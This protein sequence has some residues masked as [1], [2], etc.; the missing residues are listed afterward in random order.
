MKILIASSIDPDAIKHLE[1]K[2]DVICAF[3]AAEDVLIDKIQD[4][5]VLVFRSGVEITAKVMA[6]A[7]NL[8]LILRGGSGADNI[9][10]DYVAQ[11]DFEFIRIPGPG[12]RAVA[13][14]ALGFMFILARKVFLADKMTRQGRWM[15]NQMTGYLLKGKTLGIVGA[16]NIGTQTGDLGI[17]LGMNAI[18]CVHFP[19]EEKERE[20]KEHGIC[21][22]SFEEVISKSDFICLHV[23]LED[24]TRH[25]IN[26]QTL[27]M[28]KPGAYLI[29]LARGGV[30]DEAALYDALTNQRLAGAALDV[31]EREG[32]GKI[33]PLAELDNVVLTPHIG[34]SAFDSQREIGLIII[35]AVEQ[36]AMRGPNHSL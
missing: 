16:G 19:S 27:A 26:A 36:M 13:E 6:A 22:T 7:P 12:A 29:N 2:H 1:Q 11:R 18:G 10:L 4:R 17:A 9:D 32:D 28:M 15:K 5:D 34:A 8:K 24:S 30:I 21:L 33:S 3:G 35:D 31:H 25:L 23:P 14:L 20:L